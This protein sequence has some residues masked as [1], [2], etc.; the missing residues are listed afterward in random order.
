M[1]GPIATINPLAEGLHREQTAEP[2]AVV[3]FGATGDLTERKLLPAL[4][5]LAREMFL[6]ARFAVIG[7]SRREMTDEAFRQYAH[8]AVTRFGRIK[9]EPRSWE[10]FAEGLS[11]VAGSF[12]DPATFQ[13]LGG[14][15]KRLDGERGTAGNRVFDMAVPPSVFPPLLRQLG[16]AKLVQRL[17]E[18][19]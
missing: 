3:I 14:H 16:D 8:E 19:V 4:Y 10:A 12:D 18:P 13:K 7:S 1:P 5:A 17:A 6:P 2:A 11:Y 15:L 9:P